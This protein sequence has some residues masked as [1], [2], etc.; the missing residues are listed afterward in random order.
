MTTW[1]DSSIWWRHRATW[2]INWRLVWRLLMS[3]RSTAA[4][5]NEISDARGYTDRRSNCCC[6]WCCCLS[7]DA[8]ARIV[9]HAFIHSFIH[10]F[11]D[12]LLQLLTIRLDRSYGKQTSLSIY[13]LPVVSFERQRQLNDN[14]VYG[15]NGDYSHRKTVASYM[16]VILVVR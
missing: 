10:S 13:K 8:P 12:N 5:R 1:N 9:I 14:D 6:N 11:V 7:H 3:W 15:Y 2:L 4:D 16:M